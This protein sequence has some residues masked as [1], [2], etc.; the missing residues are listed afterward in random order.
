M[1]K[2]GSRSGCFA[3]KSELIFSRIQLQNSSYICNH[4]TL[5][6]PQ[7]TVIIILKYLNKKNNDYRRQIHYFFRSFSLESDLF[8]SC[9]IRIRL[10]SLNGATSLCVVYITVMLV[11]QS[12]CLPIPRPCK[13][14][15][16]TNTKILKKTKRSRKYGLRLMYRKEIVLEG[17]SNRVNVDLTLKLLIL[18][19]SSGNPY[20]IIF[21]LFV[22]YIYVAL[23]IKI[24]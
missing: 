10:I 9:W 19:K 8:F 3:P 12:V 4:Q 13:R 2:C 22:A 20:L 18:K 16:V 1:Q 15:N 14:F 23:G 17:H 5:K 21:K 6:N 7:K 11:C 24:G